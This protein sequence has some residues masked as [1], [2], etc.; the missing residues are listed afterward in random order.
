MSF[1]NLLCTAGY[2]Y[3]L[4]S[5]SITIVVYGFR[6]QWW[7]EHDLRILHVNK[8]E[9]N[10]ALQTDGKDYFVRLY[11]IQLLISVMFCYLILYYLLCYICIVFFIVILL[12]LLLSFHCD[13]LLC[14]V[15]SAAFLNLLARIFRNTNKKLYIL[16]C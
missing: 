11:W 4:F 2:C 3:Y 14:T 10:F 13:E 6:W 8:M 1:Q 5:L 12:H 7:D 16:P 15:K 9:V